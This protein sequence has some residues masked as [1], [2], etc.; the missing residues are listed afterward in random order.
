MVF[1]SKFKEKNELSKHL[2][3]GLLTEGVPENLKN[4]VHTFMYNDFEYLKY[5]VNKNSKI[6]IIKMEVSRNQKP[7][8]DFLKKVRNLCNKKN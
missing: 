1:G 8:K 3:K 4:S 6:G 2:L 5:L 7:N